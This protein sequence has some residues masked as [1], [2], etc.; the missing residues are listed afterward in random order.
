MGRVLHRA[1]VVVL[2]LVGAVSVGA[3]AP[4]A[5][6]RQDEGAETTQQGE[7]AMG[8][9]EIVSARRAAGLIADGRLH[10]LDARPVA[11]YL[12]GHLPGA[13][14]IED[15]CLRRSI[16][17]MP[18]QYL[19]ECDLGIVFEGAGVTTDKP[20][21]VYSDGDDA[22]AATMTAY[23]LLKAG[24][25][26]AMVLDG[27][28]EAW[29]GNHPTTQAYATFD[30]APW[31]GTSRGE[32]MVASL[33]DARRA[34]EDFMGTLVDA[35]PAKVYRGEGKG[36]ARNG[37]I[38]EAVNLDWTS[39]MHADNGALF[40]PRKE[41]EKLLADAGVRKED[42]TIVYCGTGREATLLYLYMRCVLEW[43]RVRLYEGS[44]T[45]WSSRPELAVATG[46]ADHVEV[47]ADGDMLIC[48]QPSE[49]LLR[50][51]ADQGVRL[52]INCRTAREMTTAGIAEAA[53]VKR[54]GMKYA[55]I[56]MG[57]SEGYGPEQV[58]ALARILD[59]RGSDGK[60][61]MHCASGG[62]SAQ[63]W[64]AYLVKHQGLSVDAAE[65]RVREAGML[66]PTTLQR[67]MA[68]KE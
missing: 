3:S 33:A 54:L 5:M 62:R 52:V 23:C 38:P 32:A 65:A 31:R 58:A 61:L 34:S 68:E 51:L 47:H 49:E 30:I 36:W 24:H 14:H 13:V 60:T 44:W 21:L 22:L 17:G 15:E 20:T 16:S 25:P 37:H 19:P 29:R 50:E 59:A 11:K 43:P 39:L 45:E 2:A 10:V 42:P 4:H 40:K 35:R 48:A 28:F 41:I 9:L 57:G 46:S 6:G 53:L 7:P 12:A 18:A 27:G 1:G 66:R 8:R 64:V 26:H 63:L 56:P 67:L 55:E